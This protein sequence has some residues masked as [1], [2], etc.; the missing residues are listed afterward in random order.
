MPFVDNIAPL[1]G[2][3]LAQGFD[4]PKGFAVTPGEEDLNG[5]DKPSWNWGAA[6][7]RNNEAFAL[8]A[9][10]S[11][12]EQNDPEPGFNSW[13][14]IKGTADE[15]N[16]SKLA[17]ARNQRMFDAIKT[18]IAR[19]NEDR[20]LL[21]GQPWWMGLLTEGAA[22]IAS[23]TTLLPGGVF[24]K[25]AKGGFAVAKSAA[26][27]GI[28]AGIGTAAQEGLLHGIEQTRTVA[29]SATAV[30]ASVFLGG[31]LG[32]G[33]AALL[34]KGEWQKGVAALDREAAVRAPSEVYADVFDKLK[35]AGLD[36]T[37]AA[38]NAAIYQARYE[39][40]AQRLGGDAAELYRG[41]NLEIGRGGDAAADGR[42][43]AQQPVL[44]QPKVGETVPYGD[45]RAAG[46]DV[47]TKLYHQTAKEN[48]AP[49]LKEGFDV[50]D[51]RARARLSDDEVP[52]GVFL[53]PHDRDI[54]VGSATDAA[55]MP[56]Y[57][58]RGNEKTF[59]DRAALTGF[60]RQ[61]DEY[62]R[63]SDAAKAWDHEKAAE[64]KAKF[65]DG[66]PRGRGFFNEEFEG[67][68]DAF[69]EAWSAGNKER[70]TLAR[71]RATKVLKDQKVDTVVL[72]RDAG[73]IGRS[74]PTV[75]AVGGDQ[76]ADAVPASWGKDAGRV[77]FQADRKVS[78]P[79]FHSVVERTVEAAKQ[80]KAPADQW[81]G[82][83]RNAAGVK[84]EEMQWLGLEDWLKSQ[85]GPI[86]KSQV[87]DYIA[88]NNIQVQEVSKG[89]NPNHKPLSLSESERL[90]ELRRIRSDDELT[91]EQRA[92]F[93]AL[94]NRNNA[95]ESTA[96]FS[97][98]QLPGGENYRELLLTLPSKIDP[99][100]EY[101]SLHPYVLGELKTLEDVATARKFNAQFA[102]SVKGFSDADVMRAAV[103]LREGN[104][105]PGTHEDYKSSHW[106]E[107]NV[108]A[109]VRFNDRVI[110]GKKTLLV[111]EVQSDWHQAG[112][113]KGYKPANIDPDR[114]KRELYDVREIQ[115][116]NEIGSKPY[117]DAV[118]R[119]GELV[120][121]LNNDGVPDAPFKTT[122]PELAMKRIIRYAAEN[123]YEKVAWLP[124]DVQAARYD[125]STQISALRVVPIDGGKAWWPEIKSGRGG[126]ITTD[127][128]GKIVKA[129]AAWGD[130]VGKNIS[131][132][133]GKDVANKGLAATGETTLSGVDLKLGG[134]GMA[135][136]YDKILPA[137]VGKLVKK[138]GA[139]VGTDQVIADAAGWHITPPSETVS[140]KWMVKSRDYNS[141]GLLFE[142]E[143][144]AKVALAAQGKRQSV[145]SFDV[146]PELRDVAVD[147]G[148][149]LF[150]GATDG[151]QGRIGLD[152]NKAVIQLF[153]KADTSTFMHE[154]SHL[155]LDEMVRDAAK[156]DA[157]QQVKDDLAKALKWLGADDASN[158]ST[159]HHE[160]WAR[161]F[162]EYLRSGTAPTPALAKVFQQFKEWL[163]SIYK[164]L[165]DLGP[166]HVPVSDDVRGVMDIAG[167]MAS[168]VAAATAK[169][170]PLLRA[171]HSPSSVYREIATDL[172]ENPLYLKKNFEGVA[173]Q[174]AVET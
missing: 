136:F 79:T 161:G 94:A 65:E 8:G 19:E 5:A 103:D 95:P 2:N 153:E 85:K 121:L 106:D 38:A 168:G 45:L 100:R 97:K 141:K 150:Q 37:Q 78:A 3:T 110:D 108:L 1:S 7:R 48:V 171:L 58:R 115:Q 104:Y 140:G 101:A 128:A 23:P 62:R 143:D 111:E 174:P 149:P 43:F 116:S 39:T 24:V 56:V 70:A 82:M 49:I 80:D 173:S 131:D 102:E 125:L 84:L 11:I 151:P 6:L 69:L 152:Q 117:E 130:V 21:D 44:Y 170:N 68:T 133:I 167:R 72:K 129:N 73:S 54:G 90:D 46:F 53:K 135:G 59:E 83:L 156:A 92:E 162:E 96:K 60:L 88:A 159:K 74:T 114:L 147:K 113:K 165:T 89:A 155:W 14:K 34:S 138:Y 91:R 98:Y 10:N 36:D 86:S 148:F 50:S 66:P 29:E 76:I 25:G 30:G 169:M 172:F 47:E 55:Q 52:N 163:T 13:D 77:L 26:S 137:T 154:S 16:W 22:S 9:S 20:K 87:R 4:I 127:D 144:E 145:H 75:I 105:K 61:D 166:D 57:I 109:H 28:G 93:V 118:A 63:L 33:G 134:E 51:A 158:L 32:A 27:V 41:E 18:D 17:V 15:A 146:T 35:A 123:G 120:G 142:T 71:A 42:V 132:V 164:A 119:E 67:E 64:F 99:L 81:L 157:P 31:L 160:Q 139:K 40:R 12:W 112:R 126:S 107:P 124:G 122:W